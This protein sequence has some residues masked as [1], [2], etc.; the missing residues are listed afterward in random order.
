ME[1]DGWAVPAEIHDAI[2]MAYAYARDP[3][4]TL[5]KMIHCHQLNYAISE[6]TTHAFFT[7]TFRQAH[8]RKRCLD[9]AKQLREE[10][11][12]IPA[13]VL[14]VLM[15]ASAADAAREMRLG[16]AVGGV[17]ELLE[18]LRTEFA[19]EPGVEASAQ[20]MKM[21]L[22]A[23]RFEDAIGIVQSMVSRNLTP[24]WYQFDR[25]IHYSIRHHMI[26]AA[27]DIYR[28]SVQSNVNW[29]EDPRPVCNL[30]FS[31]LV[32]NQQAAADEVFSNVRRQLTPASKVVRMLVSTAHI[33]SLSKVGPGETPPLPPGMQTQ[34]T[35]EFERPFAKTQ[36]A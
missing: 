16:T 2:A 22:E 36:L 4:L 1:A 24:T 11:C 5:W 33:A 15:M 13:E 27:M 20:L 21:F 3:K 34:E 18:T 31:L 25:L 35:E 30:Y 6:E 19:Y 32:T 14:D 7:S 17:V 23:G 26:D 28:L 9:Y 8:L 10:G 12:T 29:Q